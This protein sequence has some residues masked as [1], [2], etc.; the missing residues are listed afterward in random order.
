MKKRFVIVVAAMVGCA[1]VVAASGYAANRYLD[2]QAP[3]AAGHMA[4]AC[5]GSHAAH[6]ASFHGNTVVPAYTAA[7]L[8]DTLTI[9]N[10][11]DRLRLLAFGPHEHH[12]PYDGVTEK[13]LDHGQSLTITLNQAG[14]YSFHDHLDDAAV[15]HFTVSE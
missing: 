3:G 9:T 1:G 13:V 11:D 8:C 2:A 15:G 12:Q 5:S 10:P 4:V 14:T 7:A 6:A